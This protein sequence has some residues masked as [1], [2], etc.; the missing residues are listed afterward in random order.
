MTVR[1]IVHEETKAFT[2][3]VLQHYALPSSLSGMLARHWL[4]PTCYLDI[5]SAY[6]NTRSL[7]QQVIFCIQK[8]QDTLVSN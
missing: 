7:L 3:S 5:S 4:S 8:K 1:K 6:S 2:Q